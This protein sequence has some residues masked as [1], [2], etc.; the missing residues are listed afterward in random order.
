MKLGKED[1]NGRREVTPTEKIE[2]RI[3][4]KAI[5]AVGQKLDTKWLEKEGIAC[6]NGKILVDEK[7]KTLNDFVYACGDCV[8]GAKNIASAT[9][10]GIKTAKSIISSAKKS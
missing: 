7:N 10:A 6:E 3:F 8:T 2:V 4:D 5:L 1:A 9:V